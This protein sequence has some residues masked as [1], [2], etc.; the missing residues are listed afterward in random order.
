MQTKGW[1]DNDVFNLGR[2]FILIRICWESSLLFCGYETNLISLDL[3]M[4]KLPVLFLTEARTMG[5]KYLKL[6]WKTSTEI[7]K[8]E[9]SQC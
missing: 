3:K 7:I 2:A 5:K 8:T 6:D 1:R 4:I 9:I